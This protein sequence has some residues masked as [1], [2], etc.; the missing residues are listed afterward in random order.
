MGR[1]FLVKELIGHLCSALD[2]SQ[3][4]IAV[5]IGVTDSSISSNLDKKLEQVITKK[6][7]RRLANLEVVVSNFLVQG[8]SKEAIFE[9]LEIPSFS[10]VYGNSDSVKS[11]IHS[12]RYDLNILIKIGSDAYEIYKRRNA[13]RNNINKRVIEILSAS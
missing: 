10:D 5:L 12:D 1:S 11:A 13:E 8:L 7:G 2:C 9:I 4:S 6:T 3:R